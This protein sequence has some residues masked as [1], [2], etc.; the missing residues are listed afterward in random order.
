MTENF[1]HQGD[2]TATRRCAGRAAPGRSHRVK[3]AVVLQAFSITYDGH[4]APQRTL[5]T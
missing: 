2:G 3:C 5:Y 1:D 4:S